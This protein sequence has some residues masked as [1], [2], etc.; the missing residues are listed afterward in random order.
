[1]TNQKPEG[2]SR[3][4]LAP[5]LSSLL[6]DLFYLILL[7]LLF[8]IFSGSRGTRYFSCGP[9][10]R[11]FANPL[12][13]ISTLFRNAHSGKGILSCPQKF[14]VSRPLFSFEPLQLTFKELNWWSLII[15][16]HKDIKL[17]IEHYI[18][19]NI[20]VFLAWVTPKAIFKQGHGCK[21]IFFL[22]YVRK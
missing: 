15:H 22:L 4:F 5:I 16:G 1:M 12:A 10:E 21:Y 9:W 19:L 2:S 8:S 3:F 18:V 14:S 6:F 7:P 13:A 11:L 17:N 20:H